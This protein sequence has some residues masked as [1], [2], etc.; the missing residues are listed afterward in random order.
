MA[1]PRRRAAARALRVARVIG[2]TTRARW[3]RRRL[4]LTGPRRSPEAWPPIASAPRTVVLQALVGH[5]S[6]SEIRPWSADAQSTATA[7]AGGRPSPPGRIWAVGL[8][9]AE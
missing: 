3:R 5:A 7:S 2:T 8:V 6:D 4:R 1:R 9:V